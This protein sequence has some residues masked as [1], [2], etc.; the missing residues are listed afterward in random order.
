ML[1]FERYNVDK[2]MSGDGLVVAQDYRGRGIAKRIIITMEAV[3]KEHNI[4]VATCLCT[5]NGSNR[6]ADKDGYDCIKRLK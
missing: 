3:S 4:D 6:I 1:I 5:S 2:I